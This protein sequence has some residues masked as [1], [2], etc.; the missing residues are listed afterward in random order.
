MSN[1]KKLQ[2]EAKKRATLAFFGVLGGV[3]LVGA[4][5]LASSIQVT[6]CGPSNPLSAFQCPS[7]SDQI[8]ATLLGGVLTAVFIGLPLSFSVYADT[9]WYLYG[10]KTLAKGIV[11]RVLLYLVVF[12]E[13]APSTLRFNP[14]I[15][16]PWV[17]IT[18]LVSLYAWFIFSLVYYSAIKK[19]YAKD[20]KRGKLPKMKIAEIIKKEKKKK[21][22]LIKSHEADRKSKKRS[23]NDEYDDG[24]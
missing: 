21:A 5:Q 12:L 1:T 7:E 19:Q 24:L 22:E 18:V 13:I 16:P 8:V 9:K 14:D 4:I 10:Y 15:I 6:V 3:F 20:K 23:S 2:K 11:T 17:G